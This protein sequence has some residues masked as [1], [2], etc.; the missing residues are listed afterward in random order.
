M[1]FSVYLLAGV[2]D[3]FDSQKGQNVV[4]NQSRLSEWFLFRLQGSL[5]RKMSVPRGHALSSRPTTLGAQAGKHAATWKGMGGD[6]PIRFGLGV[7][8]PCARQG[9]RRPH[10][11]PSPPLPGCGVLALC[12]FTF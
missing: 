4:E 5:F 7:A 10:S 11:P 8:H 9:A 2:G 6:R 12:G 3:I 1:L